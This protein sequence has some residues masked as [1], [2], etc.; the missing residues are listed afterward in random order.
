FIPLD[1]THASTPAEFVA[2]TF[3]A[4]AKVIVEQDFLIGVGVRTSPG[5]S[6]SAIVELSYDAALLHPIEGP[7]SGRMSVRVKAGGEDEGENKLT[8]VRFHV[9]TVNPQFTT[10]EINAQAMSADGRMLDIRAPESHTMR[11]AP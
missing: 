11:I 9:S 1:E 4:P 2:L 6:A 3:S 5:L 7:G 10:I 8:V